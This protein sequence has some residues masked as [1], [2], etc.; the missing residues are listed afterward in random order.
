MS[1]IV[2]SK[3]EYREVC[4]IAIVMLVITIAIIMYHYLICGRVVDV[5]DH[6]FFLGIT[7]ATAVGSI[8]FLLIARRKG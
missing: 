4:Y 2:Y 8:A 6:E 1:R 5:C 3:H 7:L